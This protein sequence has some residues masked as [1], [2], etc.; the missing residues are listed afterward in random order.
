MRYRVDN[1]IKRPK[2]FDIFYLYHCNMSNS[3]KRHLDEEQ[4]YETG[5]KKTKNRIASGGQ[6][7]RWTVVY[8]RVDKSFF[9]ISIALLLV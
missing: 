2:K 6:H 5:T 7:I 3:L 9:I 1:V 4:M 8:E